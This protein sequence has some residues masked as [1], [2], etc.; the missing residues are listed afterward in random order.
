MCHSVCSG[1][2]VLQAAGRYPAASSNTNAALVVLIPSQLRAPATNHLNNA[3]AAAGLL[4]AASL[5]LSNASYLYLSVSFIQMTKSLM[6]GLVYAS[7]VV[8]GTEKY[9]STCASVRHLGSSILAAAFGLL[10]LQDTAAL[11]RGVLAANCLERW[12][13]CCAVWQPTCC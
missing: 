13:T 6:P 4:Y 3:L 2:S 9:S 7:G 11:S 12:W 10:P 1:R 8:M 5:W